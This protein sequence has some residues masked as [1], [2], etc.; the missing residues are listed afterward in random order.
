MFQHPLFDRHERVLNVFDA[1]S[2][3]RAIIA[4]HSTV[5]GPAAGGCR[6]WNYP[7]AEL[8]LSDVLRLSRGMSYK[9]A[10]AG[11]PMGGGKAVILGP[12]DADSRRSVFEAFG[13]A[14]ESLGG[15]YITAEDVGVTEL[16][17]AVVA[18]NTAFASGI[19]KESGVGG[20]PSPFTAKGV[21]IGIE[22]AVK[23]ALG[24]PD[25]ENLRVAVQGLGGVGFNLCRELTERGAKIVV[26]DLANERVEEACDLYGAE[27]AHVEQIL[28]ADADVVA[29]CALGG[30]ITEELA[31]RIRARVV[32]GGANNQ[33]ATSSAGQALFERGVTYAPD[34][35]VNAGGIIV[36]TAEYFGKSTLSEVDAA[37]ESIG[38]RTREVLDRSKKSAQPSYLVADQM[39]KSIIDRA[40]SDRV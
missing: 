4:I 39:A 9:N 24:R 36:V 30:V 6:L 37:I 3:L 26:A 40:A 11:L 10:M 27:R 28:L 19:T 25:L 1:Q 13:K 29:P 2:G 35:V 17:L 20:N 31:S 38:D 34:Y 18:S 5:L 14:V 32:A 21:R 16:D 7:D 23:F 12:V 22:A 33:I 15:S 8:A